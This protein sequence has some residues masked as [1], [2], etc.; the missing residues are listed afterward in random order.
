MRPPTAFQPG[1]PIID[2]RRKR[3][4]QQCAR[5]RA[6]PVGEENFTQIELIAGRTRAF[7]VVHALGEIVDAER[8][9]HDKERPDIA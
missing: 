6:D 2:G 3:R 1:W 9:R 4:T 8:H 5:K 7:D